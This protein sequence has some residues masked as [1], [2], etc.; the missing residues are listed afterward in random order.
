M[1][2]IG[3]D[4]YNFDCSKVFWLKNEVELNVLWDSKVKFDELSLKLVGKM[5]K[6]ICEILICCYKFVICCLV[7]IN[8]EDVFLLVMMVFVCEIDL[9]INY[10][11]LCNIE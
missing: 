3:N 5:D 10:F 11:F 8:S 7:Q 2:F 6:E 4:I 1:D 9:Y